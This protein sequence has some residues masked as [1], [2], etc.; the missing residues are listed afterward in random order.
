MIKRKCNEIYHK[1]Q[2]TFIDSKVF[3]QTNILFQ[4]IASHEIDI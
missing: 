3:I 4:F 2:K 1:V